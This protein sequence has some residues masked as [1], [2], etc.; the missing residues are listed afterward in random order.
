MYVDFHD[1]GIETGE[2]AAALGFRITNQQGQQEMVY[3][4]GSVME[5]LESWKSDGSL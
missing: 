1:I 5:H 4:D 3:S 2:E